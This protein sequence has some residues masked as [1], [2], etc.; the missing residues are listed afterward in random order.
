MQLHM[1][2]SCVFG[3][4]DDVPPSSLANGTS[5]FQTLLMLN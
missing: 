2:D 1:E 4:G 5:G 3:V